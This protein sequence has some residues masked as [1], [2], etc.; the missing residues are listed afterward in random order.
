MV[1]GKYIMSLQ[2][3]Q[4]MFVLVMTLRDLILIMQGRGQSP[5]NS[6]AITTRKTKLINITVEPLLIGADIHGI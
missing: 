4:V 3:Q 5:M 1:T 6:V 2:W